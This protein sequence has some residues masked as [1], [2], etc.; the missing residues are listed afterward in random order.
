M[1]FFLVLSLLLQPFV[2]YAVYRCESS[3][4]ISYSDLPCAGSQLDIS[5]AS[6]TTDSAD[7]VSKNE[8]SEVS[9]LQKLREQRERQDQ[10]IRDLAARGAAARERKCRSLALQVKWREEDVR[11]S[12][13]DKAHKAKIRLRRATEK[14]DSECR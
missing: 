9:R 14:F 11:E 10:Q 12:T 5:Q 3:G 1:K 13:L 7:P 8:R 4:K 2:A 6:S